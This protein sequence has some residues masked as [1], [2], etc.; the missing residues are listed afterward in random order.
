MPPPPLVF[1]CGYYCNYQSSRKF[2]PPLLSSLTKPLFPFFVPK[3][4]LLSTFIYN[5]ISHAPDYHSEPKIPLKWNTHWYTSLRTHSYLYY[6][7][8][9]Y[10]TFKCLQPYTYDNQ[11][12]VLK[13]QGWLWLL[14]RLIEIGHMYSFHHFILSKVILFVTSL[15]DASFFTTNVILGLPLRCLVPLTWNNSLS[16]L[17]H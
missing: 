9:I 17:M 1:A 6:N 7:T 13:L 10:N 15:I 3:L 8:S 12:L 4:I 14:N 5:I 16:S 2:H 11:T